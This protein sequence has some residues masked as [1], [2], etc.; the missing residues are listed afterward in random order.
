M[1]QSG[2][3]RLSQPVVGW[4]IGRT[5][6][7]AAPLP[8]GATVLTRAETPVARSDNE[9]GV[10]NSS[11]YAGGRKVA[12][13]AIEEAGDWSKRPG[14][15]VWIGLFEPSIENIERRQHQQTK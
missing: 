7:T 9:P 2:G 4:A 5:S 13:V 6:T 8:G 3:G 15:V 14:H 10:V 12:D 11:V 1:Q